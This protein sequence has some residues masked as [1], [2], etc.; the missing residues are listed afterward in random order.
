MSGE[1]VAECPFDPLELL[2]FDEDRFR[3]LATD[4]WMIDQDGQPNMSWNG[5]WFQPLMSHWASALY[6]GPTSTLTVSVFRPTFELV[7]PPRTFRRLSAYKPPPRPRG[8]GPSEAPRDE[9]VC[10]MRRAWVRVSIHN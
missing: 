8:Q 5:N 1:Q 4:R 7:R 9:R 3:D 6:D 2:P 10:V